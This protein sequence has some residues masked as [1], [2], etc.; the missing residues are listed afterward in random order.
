M[1]RDVSVGTFTSQ[2]CNDDLKNANIVLVTQGTFNSVVESLRTIATSTFDTALEI[3]LNTVNEIGIIDDGTA[4]IGGRCAA[5]L[6]AIDTYF[7]QASDY[8]VN[9]FGDHSLEG[10]TATRPA[11]CSASGTA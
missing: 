6:P 7:Q 5:V 3:E 8:L 9:E 4:D 2:V 11:A 10:V 1:C